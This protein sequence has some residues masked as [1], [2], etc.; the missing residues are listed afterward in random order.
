MEEE[1]AT[2]WLP[3]APQ[4]DGDLTMVL[5]AC[6]G[7][8]QHIY[9]SL[10]SLQEKLY[11]SL[12]FCTEENKNQAEDTQLQMRFLLEKFNGHMEQTTNVL[13]LEVDCP[14]KLGPLCQG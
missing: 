4:F 10:S 1:T 11:H 14:M 13:M 3:K 12:E 7:D 9:F 2:A 5:P 8:V 6:G